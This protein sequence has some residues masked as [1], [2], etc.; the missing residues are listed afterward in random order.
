MEKLTGRISIPLDPSLL[1]DLRAEAEKERLP[2]ASEARR[3]ILLGLAVKRGALT[4]AIEVT[5]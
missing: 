1:A 3:L 5:Q 4:P 2:V